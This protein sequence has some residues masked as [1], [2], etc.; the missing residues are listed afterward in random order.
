MAY[1]KIPQVLVV[2]EIEANE[3]TF[4]CHLRPVSGAEIRRAY[5]PASDDRILPFGTNLV[6]CNTPLSIIF[7]KRGESTAHS[8]ILLPVSAANQ[9][10]Q[11][12]VPC[13][14]AGPGNIGTA[15][16]LTANLRVVAAGMSRSSSYF[17]QARTTPRIS[18]R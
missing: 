13:I 7:S 5:G 1:E 17:W 10:R 4:G 11:S 12:G 6:K 14:L 3:D 8:A 16:R 15:S 9:N 2:V 18:G